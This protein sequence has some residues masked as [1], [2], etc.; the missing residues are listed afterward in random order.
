MLVPLSLSSQ[1]PTHISIYFCSV[2][3]SPLYPWHP[4]QVYVGSKAAEAPLILS[5]VYCSNELHPREED[6][7]S[8]NHSSAVKSIPLLLF[9]LDIFFIYISNV[10]PFPGFPFR[11]PLSL[12]HLFLLTYPPTPL[13]VHGI[14]PH[15]GFETSKDQR[16]LLPLIINKAILCYIC[17]WSHEPLHLYS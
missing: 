5:C 9:F 3:G 8:V 15:W 14:P 17:G 6:K 10:I 11:N 16:P 12:S 1:N 2:F 4:S 13:P 7:G